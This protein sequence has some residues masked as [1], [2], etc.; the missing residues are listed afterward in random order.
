M[1]TRQ[2]RI[3]RA[4]AVFGLLLV[5]TSCDTVAEISFK[6]ERL[7][8]LTVLGFRPDRCER[9][10]ATL[11]EP[12][13]CGRLYFVMETASGPVLPN[14]QL[15]DLDGRLNPGVNFGAEAGDFVFEKNVLI[16]L[17]EDGAD[18]VCASEADCAA[19]FRCLSQETLSTLLPADSKIPGASLCAQQASVTAAPKSLRFETQGVDP[20]PANESTQGANKRGMSVVLSIDNSGSIVGQLEGQGNI[21]AEA[22][23]DSSK[24]GLAAAANVPTNAER[25]SQ[26]GAL[27]FA[28]FELA[29]TGNG[30]V[31]D[32]FALDPKF[33]TSFITNLESVLKGLNSINATQRDLTPVWESHLL[34]AQAFK[35]AGASNFSRHVLAF[36]D[37]WPD[38]S[39]TDRTVDGVITALS[40]STVDATA[41]V[42]HLDSLSPTHPDALAQRTGPYSD[43]AKLACE[44]RG[45]YVYELYP[46][47]LDA[48][49]RRLALSFEAAWSV[50]LEVSVLDSVSGQYS[51]LGALPAGWYRLAS[52]MS[53]NMAQNRVRAELALRPLG[54]FS[55]ASEDQRLLFEVKAQ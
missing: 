36:L 6:N 45:F 11:C 43:Y 2:S 37:S 3:L 13:G 1:E 12:P 32:V 9:T 14:M 48:H 16:Q 20:M 47:A 7:N 23:T 39:L 8:S 41:T 28:L 49:M 40:E 46:A 54:R 31:R 22:A 25:L 51:S 35:E 30:G 42:V 5:M 18:K 4:L 26:L 44:R 50:Q 10:G 27:E 17:G 15:T 29:G 34:A 53:V 38:G 52:S 21:I 33:N 19:G 24:Q 55:D